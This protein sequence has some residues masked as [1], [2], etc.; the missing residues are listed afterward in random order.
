MSR[1]TNLKVLAD[2]LRERN[3]D[4]EV[5]EATEANGSCFLCS[6]HQSMVH[7]SSIGMWTKE[8]PDVEVLRQQVIQ[9]MT[10]NKSLWTRPQFNQHLNIWQDAPYEEDQFREIL[11]DQSRERAWA[12][13]DGVFVQATCQFLNIQ[14]DIVL[15]YTPGPIIPSGLGGP[16]QI[17][18]KNADQSNNR[19]IFYVGLLKDRDD[20]DGHYQFLRPRTAVTA[21]PEMRTPPSTPSPIKVKCSRVIAKYLKSPTSKRLFKEEHCL[22]C[23][24]LAKGIELE[25]HLSK[26]KECQKYYLR[27]FKVKNTIPILLK[28]FGCLFCDRVGVDTRISNHLKRSDSCKTKYMDHFKATSL[29]DLQ[30]KLEK[31][32]R[33][34]RPSATNRKQELLKAKEKRRDILEKKTEIDL[35]NDHKRDTSLANILQCYKCLANYSMSSKRI[36]EAKIDDDEL[37]LDQTLGSKRRFQKFNICVQC[38]KQDSSSVLG[39][40][41]LEDDDRILLYPTQNVNSSAPNAPIIIG[42]GKNVT[43]LIPATVECLGSFE[44]V[45]VKSHLQSVGVIYKITDDIRGKT[46]MMMENELNKYKS[47]KIFGDRYEGTVSDSDPKTLKQAEKV[48]NDSGLVA[49][50]S[51]RSLNFKHILHRVDQLGRV[52]LTVNL[53]VPMQTKEV[54]ASCIIQEGD[55]LTVEFKGNGSNELLTHYCVHLDHRCDTD[56]SNSCVKIPLEDYLEQVN[57]DFDNLKTKFI[58]T[59]LSFIKLSFSSLIR[60][61]VK[62]PN[63]PLHSEDYHFQLFFHLDN[64]IEIRGLLWPKFVKDINLQ[65]GQNRCSFDENIKEDLVRNV[66]SIILATS[67]KN[68]LIKT[69]GIS[70]TQAD[71]LEKIILKNQYHQ[72]QG[73]TKCPYCENPQLPLIDSSVMEWSPN[74]SICKQIQNWMLEILDLTI[75]ENNLELA[76]EEWLHQV[77]T[78]GRIVAEKCQQDLRI[79]L[80]QRNLL[81]KIDERMNRLFEMYSMKYEEQNISLL[82]ALYHYSV[83]TVPESEAGGLIVK[84]PILKDIFITEFNVALL[85]AFET[86]TE[87]KAQNA[88]E[89]FCLNLVASK[90]MPHSTVTLEVDEQ[91]TSTHQEVSLAEAMSLFDNRF[92]RS[93]SSNPVEYICALRKRKKFFKRVKVSS[94][95]T[96]RMENSESH[97]E[98][99][100]TNV[101][102]YFMRIVSEP[103][104]TLTEF[105][106]N[107]D[108]VGE[109]ESENLYKLFTKKDVVIQNSDKTCA[110]SNKSFLPD[111]IL[112][113]N[114]NVMKIRS[115]PK[116]VV[117]PKCDEGSEDEVYQKVL[118]FSPD[119]RETMTEA[120]VRNLFSVK[121]THEESMESMTVVERIERVLF[122]NKCH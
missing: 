82:V 39:V 95:K 45:K 31:Y 1:L 106:M 22:F 58:S 99:Q 74:L 42:N 53:Q 62:S 111:V 23:T 4:L 12:D 44:N 26:S 40:G 121:Y 120:E 112:L 60:N 69:L 7:L 79:K 56:C 108:Y 15:P 70:V 72:C 27:N 57:F 32:R 25:K 118:L 54:L 114:K 103:K 18:N 105:V 46:S 113:S 68:V 14:L 24:T 64:S 104:L 11:K 16:Y 92:L 83:A 2:F 81:I 36:V 115:R 100:L 89:S 8:I 86:K 94:E 37:D 13:Q 3:L 47:L 85:K 10:S 29:K 34:I 109:D 5:G 107:Y 20:Y 52:C 6:C 78:T 76:T 116:I 33:M 117:Y 73:E 55:V 51:W 38:I 48:V 30:E 93:S 119:S 96:F 41:C 49:S 110:Y 50:E 98:Q 19:P 21:G 102:R 77:F 63:S 75:E 65:L 80:D 87:V 67:N 43:C 84:R 90:V 66:D 59:Y 122:P 17:V 71:V 61:F 97:F 28:E 9:F 88:D 35:I 91:I 101:E